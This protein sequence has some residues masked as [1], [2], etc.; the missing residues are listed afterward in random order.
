MALGAT[1]WGGYTQA[2]HVTEQYGCIHDAGPAQLVFAI[3]GPLRVPFPG[4][5]G[6]SIAQGYGM[7]SPTA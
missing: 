7:L 4:P 5:F 6:S 1:I 2:G 3:L